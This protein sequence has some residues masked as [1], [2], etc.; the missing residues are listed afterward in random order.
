MGTDLIGTTEAVELAGELALVE[1][2][3]Q[4]DSLLLRS[5]Y[6]PPDEYR[7]TV[8][9]LTQFY[10]GLEAETPLDKYRAG[11]GQAL[12]WAEMIGDTYFSDQPEDEYLPGIVVFSNMTLWEAVAQGVPD[13]QIGAYVHNELTAYFK[14]PGS[15]Q[16]RIQNARAA[17]EMEVLR[18]AGDAPLT[19]QS[20]EESL[21]LNGQEETDELVTTEVPVVPDP[22]KQDEPKIPKPRPKRIFVAAEESW[23]TAAKCIEKDVNF[24]YSDNG[25]GTNTAKKFCGDCAVK[26]ECLEYALANRENFGVWGGESERGRRKILKQRRQSTT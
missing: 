9:G 11:L 18:H 7:L 25:G 10:D 5:L 12:G 24:F 14:D 6:L 22:S 13:D 17:I 21:E 23:M 20:S 16:E 19:A 4:L 1:T 3:E 2:R 15:R 8:V 26:A